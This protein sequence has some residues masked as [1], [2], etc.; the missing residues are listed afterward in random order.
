[1]VDLG[2]GAG[3]SP[4]DWEGA[5]ARVSGGCVVAFTD[6]SKDSAGR[7]AG[8]WCDS[9]EGE[10]CELVGSVATVWDGEVAGMRLALESLPMVPLLV[11]SDSRAAL[12]AVR[13]AAST[14]VARTADLRRV[15][16]LV[17]EWALEGVSLRFG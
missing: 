4:R 11:L 14:G 7:V 12:A 17:G 3:G 8:G 1:M 5:I 16:D 2:V 9:R 13:S 10:G 6:G 15:V